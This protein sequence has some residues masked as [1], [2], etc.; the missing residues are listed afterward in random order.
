MA[1]AL[2]LIGALFELA[3]IVALGF[4]DL[5]PGAIR[6]SEWLRRQE[7]RLRRRVGLA[8]RP[9]IHT[10]SVSDGIVFGGSA[11][12]VVGT[13]GT[14]LEG[15]VEYLLRRDEDAQ[16]RTNEIAARVNDLAT[17]TTR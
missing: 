8:P 15:K 11:S 5:L 12:A 4:P 10:T 9:V 1:A 17:E 14:T 16:H 3:G 13:S 7:N 2:F 6:L